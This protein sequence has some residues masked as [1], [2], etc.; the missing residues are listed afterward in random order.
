MHWKKGLN[1]IFIVLS[2][3][4][5]IGG[6]LLGLNKWNTPLRPKAEDVFSSFDWNSKNINKY[7]VVAK[8]RIEA[9]ESNKVR[10]N[11]APLSL[12]DLFPCRS[13]KY[14]PLDFKKNPPKFDDLF[15][16]EAFPQ[17]MQPQQPKKSMLTFYALS[18][19]AVFSCVCYGSLHLILLT[20]S[21]V[22]D[23]FKNKK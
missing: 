4:A 23:G 10:L 5:F 7:Y 3:T 9:C 11:D 13:E 18:T 15:F 16:R 17:K 19:G 22:L 8:K 12:F 14:R 2:I 6:T 20:I 1:R 21:W